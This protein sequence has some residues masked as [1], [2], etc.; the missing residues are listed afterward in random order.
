MANTFTSTTATDIDSSGAWYYGNESI[1]S[2]FLGAENLRIQS[3]QGGE[4]DDEIDHARVLRDGQASDAYFNVMLR[5]SQYIVPLVVGGVA[6]ADLAASHETRKFFEDL[7]AKDVAAR[8]NFHRMVL[9]STGGRAAS[10]ID[11]DMAAYRDDVRATL[12]AIKAGD[13][14][15]LADQVDSDDDHDD[16][17]GTFSFIPINRGAVC[18]DG[19]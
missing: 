8:L 4:A 13:M 12:E 2:D 9:S 1:V 18:D 6:L 7:S 10:D 16:P 11:K 15:I 3:V 19:F 5:G 14:L 17:P